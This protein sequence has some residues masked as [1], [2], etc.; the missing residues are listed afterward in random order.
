MI[1]L[2]FATLLFLGVHGHSHGREASR[3]D[4]LERDTAKL[5]ILDKITARVDSIEVHAGELFQFGSL[6]L[7]VRSCLETPTEFTP[8]SLAFVTLGERIQA[9]SDTRKL[10]SGWMFA[11]SPGLSALEHPVYDVWVI[12]CL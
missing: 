11:S 9:D 6:E 7:T 10:F 3:E 8:E 5:A 12:D 1:R 4:Y 2:L